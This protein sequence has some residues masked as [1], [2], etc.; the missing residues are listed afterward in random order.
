[1]SRDLQLPRSTTYHLLDT[2]MDAGYVTHYPEQQVYGLGL[3]AYE[4]ASGYMRHEPCSVLRAAPSRTLPTEAGTAP[5]VHRY[6]RC[7][8]GPGSAGALVL[9][10]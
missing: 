2:M 8:E 4:L 6:P 5:S 3:S 10:R 1:M 9:E 7:N